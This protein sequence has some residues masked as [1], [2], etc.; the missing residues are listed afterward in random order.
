LVKWNK[1]TTANL[2][3]LA[4]CDQPN[5]DCFLFSCSRCN[6]RRV[7]AILQGLLDNIDEDDEWTWSIWQQVNKK[8]DLHH[9]RGSIV[10]LLN[11]VDEQWKSFA[12]HSYFNREQRTYIRDLRL[13]S[14]DMS[15][16]VIQIDFAENYS[17][18]RQREVQAAHWNNVQATL[19]T[20]HIKIG[21]KH[22][23]IAIISDYMRHDT[24]FVYCAQQLIIKFVKQHFPFVCKI[25]Y[26]R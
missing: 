19:F 23:N 8:V 20:V 1:I 22:K 25:N 2:I 15:Y 3:D 7:S 12:I 24:A 10:S 18:I 21:T 17:V 11:E 16:V 14:S 4:V 13:L 6:K 9:I 26:L 5:E